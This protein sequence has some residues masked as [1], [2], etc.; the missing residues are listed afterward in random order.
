MIINIAAY[1]GFSSNGLNQRHVLID[2]S[3]SYVKVAPNMDVLTI[4][5]TRIKHTDCTLQKALQA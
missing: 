2:V 5:V 4:L 3:R 1:A